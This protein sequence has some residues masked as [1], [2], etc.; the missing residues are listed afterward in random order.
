MMMNI[1]ISLTVSSIDMCSDDQE[2]E[3]VST[4]FSIVLTSIQKTIESE[5]FLYLFSQTTNKRG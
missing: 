2:T 4:M 1:L 5:H 3:E